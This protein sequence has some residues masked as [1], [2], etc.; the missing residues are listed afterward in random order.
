[1]RGLAG[2]VFGRD[3]VA[4]AY[5]HRKLMSMNVFVALHHNNAVAKHKPVTRVSDRS[6][7]QASAVRNVFG[8]P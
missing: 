3:D 2:S 8:E 6:I 7:K 1:L 4:R 5:A